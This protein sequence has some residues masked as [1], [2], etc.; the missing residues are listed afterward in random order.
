MNRMQQS[1]DEDKVVAGALSTSVAAG[2]MM[3]KA[4]I[5]AG[6]RI[7]ATKAGTGVAGTVA[8]AAA[9]SW[10]A[11][12]LTATLGAWKSYVWAVKRQRANPLFL[13]PLT[14][15]ERPW[16]AGIQ[17]WELSDL[18]G[19]FMNNF[20]RMVDLEIVS[21]IEGFKRAYRLDEVY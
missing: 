15:F 12:A 10:L 5:R 3:Q 7:L 19:I 11:I 13:V 21:T 14:Q 16:V 9:S 17:G 2:A 1:R 4:A 20:Q 8:G 18:A 6:G